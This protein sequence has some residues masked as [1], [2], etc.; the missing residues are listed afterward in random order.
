V[1]SFGLSHSRLK[2]KRRAWE[3]RRGRKIDKLTKKPLKKEERIDSGKIILN[4][5]IDTRPKQP[6]YLI[7][8]SLLPLAKPIVAEALSFQNASHRE[9]RKDRFK[10]IVLQYGVDEND[11][12]SSA[13]QIALFTE[14]I[15]HLSNQVRL[16]V[17]DQVAYRKLRNM[18]DQRRKIA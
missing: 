16:N 14:R 12:G 18:L 13:V 15:F 3:A 6:G 9:G 2:I 11:T 7:P 10:N 5:P 8:E 1:R 4:Q 17:K